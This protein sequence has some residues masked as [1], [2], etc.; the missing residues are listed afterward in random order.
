VLELILWRRYKK[1]KMK[2]WSSNTHKATASL[3]NMGVGRSD[4]ARE[5]I[6]APL[7]QQMSSSIRLY[8]LTRR[9]LDNTRLMASRQE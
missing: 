6:S 4:L 8:S 1:I 3:V 9:S 2:V 7:K 5:A